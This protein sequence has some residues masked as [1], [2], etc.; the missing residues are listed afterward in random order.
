MT[1]SCESSQ[2][3]EEFSIFSTVIPNPMTLNFHHSLTH[4]KKISNKREGKEKKLARV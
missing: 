1:P 2:S 3:H 4:K